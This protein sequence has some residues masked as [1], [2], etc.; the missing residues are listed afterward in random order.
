M[1]VHMLH[2]LYY[3]VRARAGSAFDLGG[4]RVA[5]EQRSNTNK[6]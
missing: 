4:D 5:G 3:G 6:I 2:G 1:L